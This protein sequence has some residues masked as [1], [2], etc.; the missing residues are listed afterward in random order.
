[1]PNKT[2]VSSREREAK[3]FKKPKDCVTLMAC[4]STSG[5]IKL[6]RVLVHKSLNPRC[7]KNVFRNDLPVECYAPKIP[8]WIPRSSKHGFMKCLCLVAEKHLGREV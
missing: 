3:G 5:L 2:L 4:G 7:F 6:P 1:M 8:G